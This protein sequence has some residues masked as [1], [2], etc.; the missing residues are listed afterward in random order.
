VV[1]NVAFAVNVE[2][3]ATPL[4]LVVSV[5]VVVPLVVKMPLAPDDGAV[6]VTVAPLTG[7]DF[8]SSTVATSGLVNAVPI[9]ALCPDPLVAVIDA[10]TCLLELLQPASE[11]TR[12][13]AR[14][15]ANVLNFIMP[16]LHSRL[17]LESF[18]PELAAAARSTIVGATHIAL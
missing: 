13:M 7:F 9:G 8:L 3:V 2:E 16:P 18:A 12:I 15:L 5:S 17:R 14:I 10:A 4:E 11:I 1:L 6:N